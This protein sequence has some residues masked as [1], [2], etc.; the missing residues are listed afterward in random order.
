MAPVRDPTNTIDLLI[1]RQYILFTSIFD[2]E[3]MILPLLHSHY[4]HTLDLSER[5]AV[6]LQ[7]PRQNLNCVEGQFTEVVRQSNV[8]SPDYIVRRYR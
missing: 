7:I 3:Y 1:K 2:R 6:A 4:V 5:L 8:A